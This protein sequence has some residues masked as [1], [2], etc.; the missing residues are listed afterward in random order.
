MFGLKRDPVKQ[1]EKRYG[2]KMAEAQAA[3]RAGKI[4]EFAELTAE[5]EAIGRELDAARQKASGSGEA[6]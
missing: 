3:Q 6:S 5:A 4:P 1:L 2:K